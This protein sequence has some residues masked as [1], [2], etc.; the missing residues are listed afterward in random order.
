MEADHA[1][2]GAQRR[3]A[4]IPVPEDLAATRELQRS[5]ALEIDEQETASGIE[6]DV[7]ERISC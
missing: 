7:A 3:P 6:R 4:A 2:R 1:L 5:A